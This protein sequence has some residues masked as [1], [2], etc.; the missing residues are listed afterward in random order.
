MKKLF[1]LVLFISLIGCDSKSNNN[2]TRA[3]ERSKEYRPTVYEAE[4][5][6]ATSTI[7]TDT[8]M[9]N[10]PFNITNLEARKIIRKNSTFFKEVIGD[11]Y[12]CYVRGVGFEYS[13]NGNV[14]FCIPLGDYSYSNVASVLIRDYE[15]QQIESPLEMMQTFITVMAAFNLDEKELFRLRFEILL[16]DEDDELIEIDELR[17]ANGYDS[18]KQ[19]MIS[20]F[21][22]S[23]PEYY[24]KDTYREKY[25]AFENNVKYILNYDDDDKEM[26][27]SIEN[28]VAWE[29]YK[30]AKDK[31]DGIKKDT[32][33]VNPFN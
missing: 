7:K 33:K 22:E 28:L 32:I 23:Y 19:L 2:S 21:K 11:G 20:F 4:R 25:V 15:I 31:L 6:A 3:I 29:D 8:V 1:I 13:N 10:I 9:F 24:I 12:Q 5:N 30:K 18:L 16:L 26:E 17:S 27:L 14:C